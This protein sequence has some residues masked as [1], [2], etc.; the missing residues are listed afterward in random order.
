[1]EANIENGCSLC[2]FCFKS[3]HNSTD[4]SDDCDSITD[5]QRFFTL[6]IRHFFNYS[7]LISVD[8]QEW[9]RNACKVISQTTINNDDVEPFF[10]NV[11]I[12]SNCEK[13]TRKFS[14]LYH[15]MKELELKID[16]E[17]SK[18]WD[19]MEC[20]D[21]VA[22]SLEKD[23][24][25]NTST[26]DGGGVTLGEF[27]NTLKQSCQ[28]YQEIKKNTAVPNVQLASITLDVENSPLSGRNNDV[29]THTNSG[30]NTS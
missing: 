26:F 22:L 17:V 11:Q 18:L 8:N 9:C 30:T 1:M 28:A 5:Q 7:A 16:W 3:N 10:E 15:Q 25:A 2:I 6:L 14:T 19:S 29:D 13:I 23:K 20:A 27:R 4:D 12:C 21:N 24:L